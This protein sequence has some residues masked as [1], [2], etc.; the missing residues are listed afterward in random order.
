MVRGVLFALAAGMMWGLAF[1]AP[2]LLPGYP[3]VLQS[4]G[5]YIAL[6]VLCIPLAWIDRA[7]LRHLRWDDWKQALALSVVGN[8][9]YYLLLASAI[10]Q[11]GAPLPT[12]L[13]GTL[14]VVLTIA[15][16]LRARHEDGRMPWRNIVPSLALI[17]AGIACVNAAELQA[18]GSSPS[19]D[20]MQYAWG[21]LLGVGAVAC[22]TWYPLRNAD[23]LRDHPQRNARAWATAQGLVTLPLALL[24]YAVF[25]WY[26][27][28]QASEFAMPW[29]P[30]P[31]VF[32]SIMLTMGLLTSWLATVCW[33][34]AS[35]RLPA[36]TLA[37]L[38]VFETLC[39]LTYAYTLR[40]ERP[41]LLT[42][43]GVALLVVGV[44]IAVRSSTKAAR[45][46]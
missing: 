26:T 44:V 10:Q 9:L 24:G 16:K 28:A 27:H 21:G 40:G 7:D 17:A 23:W 4:L 34:A 35:R 39:A 12:M 3:A 22:W 20:L 32:V 2:L 25:A 38:I 31:V 43:L 15:A 19:H 37:Q 45:A 5:R 11:A 18:L 14:P 30:Q 29:G 6:G 41:E 8:L 13:I 33:N 36:S 1:I 42:L 46:V